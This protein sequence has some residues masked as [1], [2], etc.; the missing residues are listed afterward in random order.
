MVVETVATPLFVCL[1]VFFGG[2]RGVS[3]SIFSISCI[4]SFGDFTRLQHQEIT[5]NFKSVQNK[6]N[7]RT[8]VHGHAYFQNTYYYVYCRL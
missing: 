1:F 7:S 3:F 6:R 8:S 2:G 4:S 5:D